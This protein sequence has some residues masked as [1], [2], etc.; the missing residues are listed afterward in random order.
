MNCCTSL[1]SNRRQDRLRSRRVYENLKV[2]SQNVRQHVLIFM[3]GLNP[4]FVQ[5]GGI[6]REVMWAFLWGDL[7]NNDQRLLEFCGEHHLFVTNTG[8]NQKTEHKA[9][10]TSPDRTTMKLIDYVK[11]NRAI[12]RIVLDLRVFRGCKSPCAHKLL[13]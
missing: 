2:V 13:V 5:E 11:I 10:W 8:F 9:T 4:K 6:R 1:C 7:N 12:R 3:G